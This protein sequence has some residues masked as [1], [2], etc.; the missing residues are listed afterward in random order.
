[1]RPNENYPMAADATKIA[2]I[3]ML[4]FVTQMGYNRITFFKG[5]KNG[6]QS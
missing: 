4:D 6:V 3:I 5:E 1:M 2:A